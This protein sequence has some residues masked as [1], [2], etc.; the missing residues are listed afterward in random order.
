[1][2]TADLMVEGDVMMVLLQHYTVTELGGC[3]GAIT[4]VGYGIL[5]ILLIIYAPEG[6]GPKLRFIGSWIED[7]PDALGRRERHRRRLA[8]L[9]GGTSGF[10]STSMP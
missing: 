8:S 9:C 4:Y 7:P 10:S 6:F 1:M 5:L 2:S 3:F